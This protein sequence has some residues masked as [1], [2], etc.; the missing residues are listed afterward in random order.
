MLGSRAVSSS[1]RFRILGIDPG[2]RFTGYGVVDWNG[3]T[4]TAVGH[5]TLKV[6][7]DFSLKSADPSF[8]LEDRLLMIHDGLTQVIKQFEPDVFVIER[9][10]CQERGFVS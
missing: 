5:G 6:S 3:R 10:F 7:R 8:S 2:S 1:S 4:A 9:V